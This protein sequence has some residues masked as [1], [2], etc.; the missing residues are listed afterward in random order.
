MTSPTDGTT[1]IT[2]AS[3]GIG[4]ATALRLAQD[5]WTVIASARR[6]EA[7]EALADE[8]AGLA[9]VIHPAPCDVTDATQIAATVQEAERSHGP[10][11]LAILNAG[12]FEPDRAET[13][14]AERFGRT[15]D[16]NLMGTV[17]C[18]E[19]LLPRWVERRKGHLAVVSSVAGY[20]GLPRSLAYG[21]TKA[22]LINLCESLRFDFDRL[23][24][25]VQVVNPGFIRTPLTDKNDF[26][27]PFLMEVDDAADRLVRGL[28]ADRF[29]IAFP[30]RF[31][32]ILKRL[33]CL[34]YR[35]YFPLVRRT[36][37]Q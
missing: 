29:E 4:R 8:A 18:L 22:A 21:A 30:A 35:L 26:P 11:A 31:A 17:R 3:S 16:L 32:W 25:K 1:W 5:G 36:T 9:G 12:T 33:R 2:G 27:M 7:L 14:D 10:I 23:G 34:P 20:R 15:V 13:L 37:G 19:A 24:L 6:V 28:A